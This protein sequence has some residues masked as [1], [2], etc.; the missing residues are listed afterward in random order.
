MRLR[1]QP[2]AD[3]GWLVQRARSTEPLLATPVDGTTWVIQASTGPLRSLRR[4]GPPDLR[5]HLLV[6]EAATRA[7]MSKL[8]K[9]LGDYLALEQIAW[10][11]R[12]LDINCVLDVGAN[13]GQYGRALRAAGYTGRIVS[14]EPL[15]HL[16]EP[17]REA[18]SNDVDWLVFH[19]ALGDEETEAEINVV[20][21]RMS[22]ILESSTFG[23]QWATKLQNVRRET[24][25]IRRLESVFD[26]AIEGMDDP[27]VYLKM[28]TQGYDLQTFR[29]AG[30]RLSEVLGLQSEVACV[31]IYD[32]MPRLPKQ[33][34]EYESEG[35]EVVGMFPVSRHGQTMRII[36][37]DMV[38]VRTQAMRR[39]RRG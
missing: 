14:F 11:L 33:L 35:F 20:P 1:V 38:M 36:E 10:T 31:P 18:A 3:G 17:L 37:F 28:D 16:V 21:G 39:R 22:S 9:K 15:S 34:K 4:I 6:D 13:M 12:E 2:L 27:R 8:Q 30:A 5:T 24:I 23:R 32:G 19:C 25:Q 26:E 7:N 29:G